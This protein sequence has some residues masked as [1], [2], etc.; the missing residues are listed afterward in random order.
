M[1]CSNLLL[2]MTALLPLAVISMTAGTGLKKRSVNS[3]AVEACFSSFPASNLSKQMGGHN[4]NVRCQDTC[5]DKGYILAATKGDQ[6]LCGNVYP[7]GH[8]VSD[9]QCTS[10]CRSW[11]PCYGVQSC[12]G[13]PSAYTVSVVGNIDVAKQVL[14]RLSHE[15][16]T[17]TK[18]RNYMK[19]QV[20]IP[21]PQS[22]S[23]NWWQTLESEGWS[24]CGHDRY[25]RGMFR[26]DRH[27][28]DRI[29][30]IEAAH[31]TDAPSYLYPAKDDQECYNHNWWNSFDHK[32]WSTCNNGY[33]MTGLYITNGQ[34]LHNIDVA[35]C[36]RPKSQKKLWG[37]CYTLY[38]WDSFDRKGWSKCANGYYMAG[39]YRNDCD[40]LYCLEEFKCCKMGPYN[41]HSWIEKPDLSIKVKDASGQFK[42]C[43]MNAMDKT[44]ARN[45]YKC[46]SL[47]D[48]T[49]M[50]A[51]NALKFNIEDNTPLNVA[52]PT[53]IKGF[54]PVICSAHSNPYKCRKLL[55]KALLTSSSF[56]I[57]S[58]FSL[59]VKV[60][61]S[62]RVSAG[63]LGSGTKS[64]FTT[65]VTRTSSLNIESTKTNTYETAEETE[66]SVQVPANTEL[67]INYFRT[68]ADIEYKWKAVFQLLG[69]YS[70][71]WKNGQKN[72]QDVTT[73][74]AGP[75]GEIYAFG[76][77]SYPGTD[78]IRVVI[79][80][81]YGNKKGSGC[82]HQSGHTQTCN[83][84]GFHQTLIAD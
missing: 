77:W 28:P 68:K 18:Y 10:R 61:A 43:S 53:P 63:F 44:A 57:G 1:V 74:L 76:S 11:S 25:M 17:N 2:L 72:I 23:T 52:K 38:V 83:F 42:H 66:V 6:C 78:V 79:T 70:A 21:S 58:G 54:T 29:G 9:S 32:G 22:H 16:Q 73:V 51:L 82:E 40:Q 45:T 80:D 26:N 60:G 5:R 8:N 13:G 67:M 69:K 24:L 71:K 37:N 27:K 31:C 59:A 62:V 81:K 3:Y 30:L 7:K 35:K 64:T 56:T 50:L 65:E 48:R 15:W 84:D 41:G 33:Y 36:C 14:R 46:K 12:C 47:S 20:S 75:K 34:H 55:K 19:A 39:L 49:N 4:S